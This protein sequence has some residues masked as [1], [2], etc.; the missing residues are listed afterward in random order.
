MNRFFIYCKWNLSLEQNL[1]KPEKILWNMMDTA[2]GN[3][4]QAAHLQ[5]RN[6]KRSG[7]DSVWKF[8]FQFSHFAVLSLISV[9]I[10]A[11]ERAFSALRESS[12][13]VREKHLLQNV[14]YPLT[15]FFSNVLTWAFHSSVMMETKT[16]FWFT[17]QD[18][19]TG[20]LCY[21]LFD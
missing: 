7:R 14:P 4:P 9:I 19:L 5:K 20:I 15:G 3:R 2:S 16:T 1:S 17:P 18:K 6:W 12:F 11:E 13:T 21:S 10:P 8:L